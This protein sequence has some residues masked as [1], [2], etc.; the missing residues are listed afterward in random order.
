MENFPAN[1]IGKKVEQAEKECT[2]QGFTLVK[3]VVNCQYVST[4]IQYTEE[5]GVIKTVTQG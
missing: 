4:R 3:N 2:N 1:L 5:N